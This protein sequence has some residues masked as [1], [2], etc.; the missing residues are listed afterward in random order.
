MKGI[1]KFTG[2]VVA[3]SVLWCCQA[4]AAALYD[5]W[6]TNEGVSGNYILTIT[7]Q[8]AGNFLF[9]LTVNPW[10]AEALGV[11][12]D[13]GN[14]N[15][16]SLSITSSTSFP[17]PLDPAVVLYATDTTSNGCGAGCNL[18]GLSPPVASPDGE[19]E[20]VFRLGGQGFDKVQTF[21]WMVAGLAGISESDFGLVGIRA[22]QLCGQGAILPD[23]SCSGSDKSYGSVQEV[24]LPAAVWLFGSALVGFA[25]LARR[26]A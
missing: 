2:G 5:S 19:W 3:S 25:A 26:K 14:T 8:S 21:E 12:V 1:L 7:D 4:N 17:T 24:P 10:N 22:Q 6:A 20:M 11:F 15:V 16:G 18:N 23:D 13:L 9:N